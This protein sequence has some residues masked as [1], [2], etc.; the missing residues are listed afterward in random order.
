MI[1]QNNRHRQ[2]FEA[3]R[4]SMR[5]PGKRLAVLYLLTADKALWQNETVPDKERQD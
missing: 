5:K 2:I 3:E 1:F 4:L